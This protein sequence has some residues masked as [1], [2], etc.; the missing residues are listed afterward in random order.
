MIYGHQFHYCVGAAISDVMMEE[1]FMAL[2][3]RA[4]RPVGKMVLHGNFPWHQILEY[5]TKG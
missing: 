3:K 4:P 1:I 2:M 5:D